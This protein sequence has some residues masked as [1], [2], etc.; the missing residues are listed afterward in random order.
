MCA[1]QAKYPK[2]LMEKN[3][4]RVSNRLEAGLAIKTIESMALGTDQAIMLM[5][6]KR[7]WSISEQ[8]FEGAMFEKE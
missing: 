2:T 8:D 1:V 6:Y 7:C 3:N 4:S 5:K